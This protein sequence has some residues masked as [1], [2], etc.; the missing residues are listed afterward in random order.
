MPLTVSG[1][2]PQLVRV[3]VCAALVVPT[4]WPPKFRA[5]GARHAAGAIP[6][7]LKLAS[8]GLFEALLVT[9]NVPV[10]APLA[11][12]ANATLIEQLPLSGNGEPQV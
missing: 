12:G 7:P 2:E 3:I 6:V 5:E 8:C 1:A 11:V 4:F 10:R 9:V